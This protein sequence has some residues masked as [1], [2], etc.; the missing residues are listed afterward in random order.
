M[1]NIRGR[2]P[3]RILGLA[4]LSSLLVACGSVTP[5]GMGTAGADGGGQAG[6]GSAG[7]PGSAGGTAG[8]A[9]G[10]AG[11]AGVGSAGATGSGGMSGRVPAKHRASA[12][13]CSTDRPAGVCAVAVAAGTSAPT[14]AC[15]KDSDCTAGSNGRCLELGRVAACSCSYDMCTTDADCAQTGGPC[16][17]RPDAQGVVAPTTTSSNTCLAGDCRVD[18]DCG[19]GGYC[20]PS[21]GSC[22]NYSGVTGYYCHTATDACVD[23]ADCAAQGAGDCRYNPTKKA[24]DCETTQCAG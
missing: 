18:A 9:G 15:T 5:S 7:A 21:L 11:G 17:C 6:A 4:L 22:G 12:A 14:P 20:S 2:I 8:G 23:D 1:S 10:T 3:G 13:A 24:W 19:A 16:A